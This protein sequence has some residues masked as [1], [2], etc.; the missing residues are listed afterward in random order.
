MHSHDRTFLAKIGFQ[1]PDR[2]N[3][4]HDLAAAYL[5]TKTHDIV[6]VVH[7]KTHSAPTDYIELPQ[8]SFGL[9]VV[10]E[11][12]VAQTFTR[13]H[14]NEEKARIQRASDDLQ[15]YATNIK[16]AICLKNY[17][18]PHICTLE[19]GDVHREAPVTRG[20]AQFAQTIGFTDLRFSFWVSSLPEVDYFVD[21]GALYSRICGVQT[22]CN[23]TSKFNTSPSCIVEVKISKD[24]VGDAVKQLRLYQGILGG[25]L[26]LATD[27][28]LNTSEARLLRQEGIHHIRLGPGFDTWLKESDAQQVAVNEN[29]I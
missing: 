21:H 3:P 17:K 24:S 2:K 1:D 14:N 10:N 15:K 7:G 23:L 25:A 11:E 19:T 18:T 28:D 27:Y 6:R 12:V 9:A 22:N 8:V 5:S 4:R 26:V 16:H 13:D 20:Q 29:V